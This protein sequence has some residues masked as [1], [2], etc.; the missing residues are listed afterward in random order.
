M[1][2]LLVFR[3]RVRNFYQ[4]YNDF[5]LPGLKFIFA[6][7]A[8]KMIN[9]N[10]GNDERL[11]SLPVVLILSL[12]SAFT[13]SS[14]MVLLATGL[15]VLQI[16][17]VSNILSVIV[18]LIL[19]ILYLLFARFTPSMG[20]VILAVPILYLLKIPYIIPIL[21]GL[22]SSPI[23]I[24]P[25]GCGVIVYYLFQIVK[26]AATLQINMTIE[27][28]LSLYT[29]VI[30][31]LLKNKQLIMT[32]VIFSL[33]IVVVYTIRRMRMDYSSEIA[34][35]AG[36]LTGILGFF[37][38]YFFVNNTGNIVGLIFGTIVSAIIVFVIHF[39]RMTLDYSGVE[40]TQFED[41]VYY[42]Y[43][44]AVPK[45]TVTTPQRNI[46]HISGSN[47]DRERRYRESN[48]YED[49][50]YDEDYDEEYEDTQR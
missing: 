24:I 33:T 10:I 21:M 5:I 38:S 9:T 7:I 32:I 37:M 50:D 1:M 43:V 36:A 45:I 42:Y 29:Y 13:P 8:F 3:E 30:D 44:K 41:D 19:L 15:A 49:E 34:I 27:D 20:Y 26:S 18:I 16:Y 4:K 11:S 47:M 28:T 14:I 6:F 40:H 48:P 46:K 22:I 25:M 2:P 23:A 39:F 35:A 12:L 31:N 17:F